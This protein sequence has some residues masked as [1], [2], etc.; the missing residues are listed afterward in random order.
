MLSKLVFSPNLKQKGFTVME[1]MVIIVVIAMMSTISVASYKNYL[2]KGLDISRKTN[3][4]NFTK[5]IKMDRIVKNKNN[6]NLLKTQIINIG[7]NHSIEI[8]K[9]KDNKHYFYGYSA[10]K[11]NFFLIVC[12]ENN[13]FFVNGT[14]EGIKAANSVDSN[15]ACDG[16]IAPIKNRA[17]PLSTDASEN[18]LDSYTIYELS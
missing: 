18:N 10:K 12:G 4:E 6:F 17:E 13:K 15:I 1:L 2:E 14:T 7:N 16:S 11:E 3:I 8:P 9:A 5:I